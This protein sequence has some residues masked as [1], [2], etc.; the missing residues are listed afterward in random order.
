MAYFISIEFASPL[1]ESIFSSADVSRQESET[2]GQLFVTTRD[3]KMSVS[4]HY[5][6]R[7]IFGCLP[8]AFKLPFH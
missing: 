7:Y 1:V 6:H 5:N 2:F 4:F 3:N 8:I